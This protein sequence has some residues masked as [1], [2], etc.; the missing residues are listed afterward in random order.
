M[1]TFLFQ[2][3]LLVS[4]FLHCVSHVAEFLKDTVCND[5]V[6]SNEMG[7]FSDDPKLFTRVYTNRKNSRHGE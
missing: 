1:V 6:L 3:L 7:G 4:L 5:P 2:Q